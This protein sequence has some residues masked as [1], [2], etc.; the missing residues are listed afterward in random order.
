MNTS[1][2]NPGNQ[3]QQEI[4]IILWGVSLSPYVRKVQ[5]ALAEKNL[6]Y[7]HHQ[8][9]PN[10]LAKVLNQTN[11][12]AFEQ[13]SPLGKIPAIQVAD[14]YL[15]DSAVICSYVDKNFTEGTSLY[16]D[17]P[18]AYGKTRWFENYADNI[19]TEVAYKKIFVE[20]VVKPAI[21]GVKPEQD[22]IEHAKT[23]ELPPY[24]DYLEKSIENCTWIAGTQF[25]IAD[26]ALV[27]HF[28]S[29]QQAGFQVD[30]RRWP[31]LYRYIQQIIARPTIKNLLPDTKSC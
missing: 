8:I 20:A 16:P 24:L 9:L 2:F 6:T 4:P 10:V 17:C 26:I 25:S 15:A 19:F 27:T 30:D 7:T 5:I 22:L 1:I 28:I 12:E 29:L 11:P 21:F 3:V 18:Q 23:K 14:Y 13:A 31:N